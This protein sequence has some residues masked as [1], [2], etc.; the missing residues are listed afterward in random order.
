MH[1][2]WLKDLSLKDL[3]TVGGK[4]AALGELHQS[5]KAEN[6]PIPEG[7]AVTSQAYL[8][9]LAANAMVPEI[10]TLLDALQSGKKTLEQTG[11]AIRKL[12]H[13]ARFPEKIVTEIFK[14]VCEMG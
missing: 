6:M 10:E 11:A 13:H 8:D 5:L 3:P 2:R 1:T 4:N 12:F 7:F 14:V 9:F